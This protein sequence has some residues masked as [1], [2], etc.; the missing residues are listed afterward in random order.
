MKPR[1]RETE[2]KG[3]MAVGTV[4]ML[5]ATATFLLHRSD[6]TTV[7]DQDGSK[8]AYTSED[9]V[10]KTEDGLKYAP[11][12][13]TEFRNRSCPLNAQ[14][15]A[16]KPGKNELAV[17]AAHITVPVSVSSDLSALPPAPATVRYRESAKIGASR[18]KTIIAGHVDHGPGVLSAQGGELSPFGHL[19]TVEPCS[20]VYVS[21]P[22]ARTHEYVVTDMYTVPQE[23]IEDT[24]IYSTRGKPELVMVTCS[25]PSVGDTGSRAGF[26]Y[27]YNL[28]VEAQPVKV[29]P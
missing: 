28:V 21:G 29:A 14:A 23:Q 9:R 26:V 15:P 25:G 12:P 3:Y 2:R 5:A 4:M 17:P 20:H 13:A 10:G 24:G 22:D 19:H 27:R 16:T 1:S 11:R 18:G 7:I 8:V 6:T